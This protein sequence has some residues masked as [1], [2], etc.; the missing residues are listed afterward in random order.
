MNNALDGHSWPESYSNVGMGALKPFSALGV[1]EQSVVLRGPEH[2]ANEKILPRFKKLRFHNQPSPKL[3]IL[4]GESWE[5]E[6]EYDLLYAIYQELGY[7][8]ARDGERA[9]K[10]KEIAGRMIEKCLS[11]LKERE[12]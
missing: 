2:P 10:A 6:E 1:V 8:P 7:P 11:E 3:G 5:L 4:D 12:K 9:K